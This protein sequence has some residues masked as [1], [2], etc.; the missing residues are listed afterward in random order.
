MMPF[1]RDH[2]PERHRRTVRY[3]T[4]NYR[5]AAFMLQVLA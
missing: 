1:G 5:A 2:K 3:D 4:P